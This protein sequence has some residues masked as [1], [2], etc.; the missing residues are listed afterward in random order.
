MRGEWLF[1]FA[2]LGLLFGGCEKVTSLD[3]HKTLIE[4]D[5]FDEIG[6]N[7]SSE[8]RAKNLYEKCTGCHGEDGEKSALGKSDPI[9]GKEEDI[10]KALLIG[11]KLGE[12]NQYGMGGLMEVQVSNLSDDDIDLLA[13]F[14][15]KLSGE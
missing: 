10:L 8:E 12:L 9:G 5:S 1:F 14:I 4:K 6:N 11:Y 15:S 2:I 13:E 7:T 3:S